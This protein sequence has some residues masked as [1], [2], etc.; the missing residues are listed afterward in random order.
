MSAPV[1][2]HHAD[3]EAIRM[4]RERRHHLQFQIDRLT[5]RHGELA[6]MVA[7]LD[8]R[9][10]LSQHERF[11]VAHLKKEKLATKDELEGLRRAS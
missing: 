11:L 1:G 2:L 9:L 5:Q 3:L 8:G 4:A 6:A 10:I 7:E